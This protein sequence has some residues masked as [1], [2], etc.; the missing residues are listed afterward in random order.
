MHRRLTLWSRLAVDETRF[1]ANLED[2]IETTTAWRKLDSFGRDEESH[3][4]LRSSRDQR[5]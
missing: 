3:Q 1:T 5:G 4:L 2:P